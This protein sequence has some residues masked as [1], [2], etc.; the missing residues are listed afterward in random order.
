MS[1]KKFCDAEKERR[2]LRLQRISPY[3]CFTG[4]KVNDNGNLPGYG[5]GSAAAATGTF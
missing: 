1:K 5:R 3:P 4:E 2:N